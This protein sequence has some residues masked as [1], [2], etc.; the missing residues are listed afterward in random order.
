VAPKSY[1]VLCGSIAGKPSKIGVQ[2]HRAG[3]Q[4]LGLDYTYVAFGVD[5]A[6]SALE[7]MRTLGIR[8]F[9]VT[10]PLKLQVLPYLDEVDDMAR[11]IGAVNTIVNTDGRLTGHNTDW[12]GAVRAIEERTAIAGKKV[13]V[14]GAGGAARAIACGMLHE[15]AASVEI[16]NRTP[17]TAA[18]LAADLGCRFGGGLDALAGAEDYDIL[19]QTTSVGYGSVPPTDCVVP[20]GILQPG[21]VVLDIVAEPAETLLIKWA[22]EA[23]CVAIP[24]YRMRLHQAHL[25]F[26][27]YTERKLPIEVLEKAL[28]E[29]M[30]LARGD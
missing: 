5:D 25:Q 12:L 13:I 2:I 8:G 6:R 9:G 30:G 26:E 4:Y 23:G 7:A 18:T 15:K 24:G 27:L 21:R 17:E 14:V 16:F 22:R 19:I 20:R 28:L 29:T 11:A 3:Y 10:M 1:P